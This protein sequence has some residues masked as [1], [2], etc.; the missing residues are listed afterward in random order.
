MILNRSQLR[1][2]LEVNGINPS[3][4][5]GQNFLTDSNILH[6]IVRL[7]EISPGDH[8][9]EIGPGV[10][11]LTMA[12]KEAGANITAIE[13]DKRLVYLLKQQLNGLNI[14]IVEADAMKLDWKSFLPKDKEWILV[15]N[16]PYNVATPL[17]LEILENAPYISKLMVM[18]QKEA[19]ERFVAQPSTPA[20]GAVTVKISYWASASIQAKVPPQVFF[21]R[22]KVES[23]VVLIKRNPLED[24]DND[25]D[26]LFKLINAGFSTRRK[27]LR[28]SLEGIIGKNVLE[29]SG[30]SPESR[31][32]EL[33]ILEWKKLAKCQQKFNEQML[34]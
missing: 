8:V 26:L 23:S 10:G 25:K 29:Q 16:L 18:V 21:P 30:I 33:T 34:N 12:L 11:S 1:E 27:M 15:A 22:P 6:K 9:V 3:K 28:R 19:A 20:Y 7:A 4:A 32:E 17:V 2:L 14:T 13:M 5:L 31:A 24:I